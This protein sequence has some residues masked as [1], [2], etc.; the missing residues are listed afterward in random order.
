MYGCG[1]IWVLDSLQEI[2]ERSPCA[3]LFVTA[4][5]HIRD[6]IEKCLAGRVASL[7]IGHRRDD[8]I[9]YLRARLGE[10]EMPDAMVEIL[11]AEILEKI[12]ENI[13]QM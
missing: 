1:E 2:L 12:P 7:S 3:Q 9:G 6:E 5:P 4:R 13:S 8:I 10:D 11:E